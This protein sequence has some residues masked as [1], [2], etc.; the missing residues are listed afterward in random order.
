MYQT[1]SYE[2][3]QKTVKNLPAPYRGIT[4]SHPAT[5][6]RINDLI[7]Q[8]HHIVPASLPAP[9]R[10]FFDMIDGMTYGDEAATGV[11]KDGV[12]YHGALRLTVKFPE[13]WEVR[14]APW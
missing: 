5:E 3:Y 8:S 11:V 13:Q 12:Y 14:N 2:A 10:D 7:V 9:E 6:K 4:G 1:S